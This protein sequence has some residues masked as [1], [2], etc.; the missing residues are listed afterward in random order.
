MDLDENSTGKM[1]KAY[2]YIYTPSMCTSHKGPRMSTV[3]GL[4]TSSMYFLIL[5]GHLG[6]HRPVRPQL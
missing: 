1:D 2:I 4:G 5:P 3:V 6:I